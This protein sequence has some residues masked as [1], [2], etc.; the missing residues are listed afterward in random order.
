MTTR[1]KGSVIGEI[2]DISIFYSVEYIIKIYINQE[3]PTTEPW[4][5]PVSNSS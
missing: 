5:T 3:G 4:G 2:T 1:M